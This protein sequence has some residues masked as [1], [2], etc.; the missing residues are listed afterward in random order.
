MKNIRDFILSFAIG[1]AIGMPT[2][3]MT[4][5]AIKSSIGE[6]EGLLDPAR[7]L[8][9]P[10][11]PRGSVTD[12]TGQVLYLLREFLQSGASPETTTRALL[13]WAEETEAAARGL[14]G[15]SS[16]KALDAAKAGAPIETTGL[17]GTTCGGMMRVPAPFAYGRIKGLPLGEIYALARSSLLPTHNTSQ[18]LEA[19]YS[20]A[21]ALSAAW[22]GAGKIQVL[23]SA[24]EGSRKGLEAAPYVAASPGTGPR[25][26]FLLDN[27]ALVSLPDEE[28]GDFLY[29]V[30]GTGLPSEDV[31]AAVYGIF[32]KHGESVFESI[33]AAAA[34]G[35]DTDTIA[36]LSGALAYAWTGELDAPAAMLDEVVSANCLDLGFIPEGL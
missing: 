24:L 12:D 27:S 3:F 4:R 29:G 14:I 17:Q 32:L 22:E 20:Y 19:A 9:H 16:L 2:E 10:N 34:L 18:A 35:G 5:E 8:C 31:A 23:D 28:F 11:L 26:R 15:P 25:I 7:S 6:V 1:D 13:R 36:A 21:A 30:L 33:R